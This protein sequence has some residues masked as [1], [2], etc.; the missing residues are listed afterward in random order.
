M[1]GTRVT[2]PPGAQIRH[3]QPAPG[4]GALPDDWPAL[5]RRLYAAR[6]VTT[7]E[8]LDYRLAALPPPAGL[9][10][11]ER[12]AQALA[13]AVVS[14]ARVLVV[15]DFDADG[16]TSTA[17]AVSALRAMGAGSVDYLVPNRFDFGYGLSPALVEVAQEYT[18]DLILTVDNGISANDGVEAANAAGIEVVVTDHHLPGSALPPARA[19]VNPQVDSPAFGAPHLAGVGVCFYAMLATRAAL[20][21]RDWFGDT[22]PEPA[23][24]DQLDRVALGTIADVVPLDHVNRLLVD[25]GLRRIRGGRANPGTLALLEAA[26]RD[27]AVTTATDL[28]FGAAPRLNAAGRLDDMSIGIETLL[29]ADAAAAQRHAGRLEGLN[30]ER[31]SLE[32]QMRDTAVADIEAEAAAAEGDM[33]PILCLFNP[34]WHQGVVGIVASR[35]LARFRRPVIAFAPGDADTLKGS[36]RSV[37]GLHMRDLLDAV[38]TRSDGQL[39]DRFGGHAMAAGLTLARCHFEPFKA[40]LIEQARLRL[41]DEPVSEV[42]WTDGALPADAYTLETAA[43]LRDAGPWGA[44]FPEPRFN[45]VFRVLDQRV[46]GDHH[47]KL[48]LSPEIAPSVRIDAIAFNAAPDIAVA[49]GDRVEAVFRL[50]VNRFRGVDRPQL[51]VD[52]LIEN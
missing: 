30:R 1:G 28:G 49:P 45:D 12:A 21:E 8:A 17:V 6:G 27:P 47:L 10:G 13:E 32:Q 38:N 31:R 35:L 43:M 33:A 19:I 44:E 25:Q 14:N 41:G 40:L 4:V 5:L 16:A 23:L 9:A 18:P 29:A 36:A 22:R 2:R 34:D 37:P 7:A 51:V 24:V 52:H 50:E 26:G 39:V 46:V 3:R 15:G 20:R 11:L 48:A 42:I